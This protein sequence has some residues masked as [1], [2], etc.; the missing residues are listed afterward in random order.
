MSEATKKFK[1]RC[2]ATRAHGYFCCAVCLGI[3]HS[4]CL[5][6]DFRNHKKIGEHKVYCS[7]KCLLEKDSNCD[8]QLKDALNSIDILQQS[9]H[10]LV[11]QLAE[12]EINFSRQIEEKDDLISSLRVEIDRLSKEIT[13]SQSHLARH[14]RKTQDFED[15][16]LEQEQK[17]VETLN[18]KRE[19]ITK[20]R[21]EIQQLNSNN[22][23]L[24]DSIAVHLDRVNLLQKE[25]DELNAINRSMIDSIRTL[26]A[27][28]N[29]GYE[30]IKRLRMGVSDKSI[31]KPTP[32]P[33]CH[34]VT[35]QTEVSSF[36]PVQDMCSIAGGL[37]DSAE[38]D[39]RYGLSF[40]DGKN[41]SECKK[42]ILILCDQRGYHLDHV[43][44]RSLKNVCIQ[45][46]VKPHAV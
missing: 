34:S 4:S 35:I 27:E 14:R 1:F 30:E 40:I 17:M 28:N 43:L 6:R 21:Q 22:S 36:P 12:G 2:C 24:K 44:N 23:A 29:S 33:K 25:L 42:R 18:S 45:S 8:Q 26:E 5:E 15:L 10:T 13:S 37:P 16:A 38:I 3:F 46:I 19:E 32:K 9:K 11:K 39:N 20:L 41:S 31:S 7:E